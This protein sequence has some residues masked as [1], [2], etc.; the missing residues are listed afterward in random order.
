[1][2]ST[3]T[4]RLAGTIVAAEAIIASTNGTTAN[5]TGSRDEIPNTSVAMNRTSAK[6]PAKRDSCHPAGRECLVF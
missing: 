6:A 2:G 1:M 5:V 3:R 4:A